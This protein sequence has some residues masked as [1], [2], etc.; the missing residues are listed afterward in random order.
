MEEHKYSMSLVTQGKNRFYS[1]TMQSEI[2]AKTCY[3]SSRDENPIDGFQRLLDEKRAQA[4]ADYID[5]DLGTIP[6]AIV[7]S[8]QKEAQFEITGGGKTI[9]FKEHPKA[10][11]ILDGQHRVFGFSKA[12]SSVR[13]PVV[14]YNNLSRR[15]ESR[16][17][18]DINTRQKPV[19]NE[20]LFDIKNLA[21]YESS[22]EQFLREI[23]DLF[24]NEQESVLLGLTSPAKK[25][26]K[27]ISRVTFNSSFKPITKIFGDKESEEIFEICNSY[28]FSFYNGLKSKDLESSIT[29]SVVFR[30]IINSF[31]HFAQRTKAR[32][33][34]YMSDSFAEVLNPLFE[35]LKTSKITK[36]GGS[37]KDLS[38]YFIECSKTEFTL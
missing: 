7:L 16:I 25:S 18:I 36:P 8:A 19:P 31:P 28:L 9:R 33:S 15:D 12:K 2:L 3:I 6:T 1:L 13:V 24:H 10:F 29:N 14:I 11:L 26:I 34:N 38:K 20:L 17:F 37:Y 30:A 4:I 27:K 35:K 5:N 32:Y 21:E 23:F 22:T